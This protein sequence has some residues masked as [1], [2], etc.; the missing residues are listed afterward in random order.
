MSRRLTARL[1]AEASARGGRITSAAQREAR[2]SSPSVGTRVRTKYRRPPRP[3]SRKI[4]TCYGV[5]Q[6]G[7][8]PAYV[9]S[10]RTLYRPNGGRASVR[11]GHCRVLF[12]FHQRFSM[13]D[14]E[15]VIKIIRKL[16]SEGL[17]GPQYKQP[18]PKV[19]T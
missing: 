13:A 17:I 7:R 18:K 2:A 15:D 8:N 3:I 9:C 16:M 6:I 12:V 4:L 10:Q 1:H 19:R 11:C 14:P 5:P